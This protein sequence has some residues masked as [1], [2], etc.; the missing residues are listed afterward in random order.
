MLDILADGVGN[1]GWKLEGPSDGG[2]SGGVDTISGLGGRLWWTSGDDDTG[3]LRG[4][5][6]KT[7]TGGDGDNVQ[8][9]IV[10]WDALLWA[11]G[12]DFDKKP[13]VRAQAEAA[14]AV[15]MATVSSS[16]SVKSITQSSLPL[17]VHPAEAEGAAAAADEAVEAVGAVGC[18]LRWVSTYKHENTPMANYGEHYCQ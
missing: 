11:G 6:S 16:D 7:A 10:L 3:M 12:G 17:T 4:E 9:E 18:T 14:E 1:A 5:R 15:G 2:S 13:F 8:R